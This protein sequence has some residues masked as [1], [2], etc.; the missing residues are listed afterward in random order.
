MVFV[1][2]KKSG[3]EY[4]YTLSHV[5]H[6]KTSDRIGSC[7]SGKIVA[8][9]KGRLLTYHD[10]GKHFQ[11]W[12]GKNCVK[13]WDWVSTDT[14]CEDILFEV[15]PLPDGDHLL[16][17]TRYK[18]FLFNIETMRI[19]PVKIEMLDI[20]HFCIYPNGQTIIS[21]TNKGYSKNILL[22]VD[23]AAVADYR[24]GIRTLVSQTIG[25]DPTSIVNG[26]LGH[27]GLWVRDETPSNPKASKIGQCVIC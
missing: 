8:L 18:L 3:D 12:E 13:E 4:E 21:A 20:W 22:A 24:N 7:A 16:V 11:L 6:P 10:S 27:D 5:I 1:Y 17:H 14:R 25:R 26:Y 9:S 19:K 2:D 15:A 23:F